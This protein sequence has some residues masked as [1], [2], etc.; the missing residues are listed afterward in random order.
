MNSNRILHRKKKTTVIQKYLKK[1]SA[2]LAFSGIQINTTLR[3]LLTPTRMAEN[4]I[5]T[6]SK[7]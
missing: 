6:V 5:N 3:F 1:S 7:I 4:K 2:R